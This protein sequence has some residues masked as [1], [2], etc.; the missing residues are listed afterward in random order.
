MTPLF[1]LTDVT[2]AG[3]QRPRLSYVSAEIVSGVTVVLGPSGSGKTSLLNLLV[4]ME[5]PDSGRIET[6]I[7]ANDRLPLFW[8]PADGGLWPGVSIVDHLRLVMPGSAQPA[9]IQDWLDRFD[10]TSA[11]AE[12]VEQLSAGERSRL[13]LARALAADAAVLV[14][15]EPLA[16]VDRERLPK[17]WGVIRET[18]AAR[19]ASLVYAAHQVADGAHADHAVTM[20]AGR[21]IDDCP[22]G[23]G[24]RESAH[25]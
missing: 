8:S 1:R 6:S 10:L 2:L 7:P 19:G 13:S 14:L 17:Y 23:G 11:A 15:D 4:G 20:E 21:L 3:A 9:A 25:G 18:C 5:Q 12:T 24:R 22:A 16:H